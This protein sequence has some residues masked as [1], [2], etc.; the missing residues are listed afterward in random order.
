MFLGFTN[1]K[2]SK[3]LLSLR[4]L[5]PLFYQPLPFFENKQN[6]SPHLFCNVGEIQLW[7]IKTTCFLYLLLQIRPV[8]I[9]TFNIKF[10][11]LSFTKL[12]EKILIRHTNKFIFNLKRR[13]CNNFFKYLIKGNV[14]YTKSLNFLYLFLLFHFILKK[15]ILTQHS[16]KVL[17]DLIFTRVENYVIVWLFKKNFNH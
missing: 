15:Y 13:K 2:I 11:N 6:S 10:E 8:N 9:K 16:W 1:T 7:L 12:V 4:N 5:L 14:K 3:N 17:H